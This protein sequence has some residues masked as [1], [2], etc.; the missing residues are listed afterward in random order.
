MDY[1]FLII[2]LL[3]LSISVV[4]AN[5]TTN[6]NLNILVDIINNPQD[7]PRLPDNLE[8]YVCDNGKVDLELAVLDVKKGM[9]PHITRIVDKSEL[10]CGDN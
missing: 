7:Y 1:K 9:N 5:T 3:I 10:N 4:F 6:N 8:P 2:G